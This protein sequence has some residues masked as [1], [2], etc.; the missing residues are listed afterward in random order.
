MSE[1]LRVRCTSGGAGDGARASEGADEGGWE[2]IGEGMHGA[3][4]AGGTLRG[5]ALSRNS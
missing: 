2:G 3:S 4:L 5:V 1:V